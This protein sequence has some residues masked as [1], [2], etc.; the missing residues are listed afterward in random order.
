MTTYRIYVEQSVGTM[1]TVEAENEDAAVDAVMQEGFPGLM[2]L[3]HSYP[4]ESGEWGV[5]E[6]EEVD[7]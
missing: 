3:D 5:V 7:V 4:D 1:R 2:F 6:V